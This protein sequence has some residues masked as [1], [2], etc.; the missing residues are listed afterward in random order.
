[1]SCNRYLIT[2]PF[3]YESHEFKKDKVLWLF[4]LFPLSDSKLRVL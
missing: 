3:F 4:Y 2:M 1:M